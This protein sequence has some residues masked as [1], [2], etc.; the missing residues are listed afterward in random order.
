[1]DG[2]SRRD[3]LS[4]V[5]AWGSV[6]A[7][8][9][10]AGCGTGGTGGNR[11]TFG[12]PDR[13]PSPTDVPGDGTGDRT[14]T[15]DPAAVVD[16]GPVDPPG[17]GP[18][19]FRRWLPAPAEFPG[20]DDRSSDGDDAGYRVWNLDLDGIRDLG[21]AVPRGIRDSVRFFRARGLDHF[22]IGTYRRV[23]RMVG[24]GVGTATV[25]EASLDRSAVTKTLLETGYDDAGGHRGYRLFDRGDDPRGVAL[26]EGDLV[27]ANVD[28]DDG[29]PT[30]VV[31][32]VLDARAGAIPR[33]H[34]ASDWFDRLSR[35]AGGD[36]LGYLH[37]ARTWSTPDDLGDVRGNGE[38]LAFDADT[39]YRRSVYAFDGAGDADR[40][41]QALR[42]YAARSGMGEA[43]AVEVTLDGATA[44]VV[45]A[46]PDE[47]YDDRPGD[48]GTAVTYPQITWGFDHERRPEEV[49]VTI[50]H[51]AG[52]EV[53]ASTLTIEANVDAPLP[54]GFSEEDDAVGP[55]DS[56]SFS[57]PREGSGPHYRVRLLWEALDGSASSLLGTYRI[58]SEST[59]E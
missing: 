32:S 57:I 34:E 10:V 28:P 56:V 20:Q 43:R 45:A 41:R 55:G 44:E 35:V 25:V 17:R 3:L 58:E 31:R 13:T 15:L 26:G 51:E 4:R 29:P 27:F 8:G 12:V 59:D 48:D 36:P 6:A 37:G 19:A 18:P 53:P 30:D 9:A 21:D 42:R 38:A 54:T 52:T 40:R 24:V 11:T 5:A 47:H 49:A 16:F 46:Y 1:M 39:T 33:Y 7:A 50:T 23:I 2:T 14:T 22:G